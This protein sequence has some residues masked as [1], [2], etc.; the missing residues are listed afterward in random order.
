MKSLPVYLNHLG[1]VC[2]LGDQH[3][4][5]FEH[6][7]TGHTGCLTKTDAFSPGQ[8]LALGVVNTPL[9]V[10]KEFPEDE[11]TRTNQLLMAAM[12]QIREAYDQA[13]SNLNPLR[14]GIVLGTSTSG[15]AEG[16]KAVAHWHAEGK[17]P[18]DFR[19]ARQE[20]ASPAHS[21]ARWLDI[22]GPAYVISTACSSSAKA[23]ASARRL[24]RMDMCDLVIAGGVDSLCKLT[25]NGFSALESVSDKPCQPF[26]LS[27]DGINIG[28]GAALFLL[29]RKPGK[30][31]L[32]GVGECSDAHHI[33]APDPEGKGAATAMTL[34]LNDAGLQS[35]AIDYINL[36]GTATAQNDKMESLAVERILGTQ[37]PCSSTKPYTGHTL[38]AAGA[39]EAGICWLSLSERPSQTGSTVPQHLWDG[40]QDPSLADINLVKPDT[41]V[42]NLR[43]AMSNSFAF[44][45]NNISLIMETSE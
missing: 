42:N 29:T 1:I 24:L 7:T 14:I 16:E 18:A 3:Q 6:L 34:A 15:I 27:R 4:V 17:L 25:V 13:S 21:L 35:D 22:K 28:E 12:L 36:H 31:R 38:G 5:I 39:I 26:S 40:Q 44:G 32:S 30:I 23:L 11:Q 10:L 19:Y 41:R 43:R 33:S 9:P 20:M 37:V 45:G 8:T 2:A